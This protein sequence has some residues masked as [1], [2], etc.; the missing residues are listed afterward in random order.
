MTKNRRPRY[1]DA[2]SS[3]SYRVVEKWIHPLRDVSKT[4]GLEDQEMVTVH[5]MRRNLRF[6]GIALVAFAALTTQSQAAMLDLTS[7]GS[8]GD[9]NGATFLTEDI[10]PTGSGNIMSFVRLK[11]TKEGGTAI[12][13]GYNTDGRPTYYQENSSPT[14][15]HSLLLTDVPLVDMDDTLFYEFGLD[16]NQDGSNPLLSLDAVQIYLYTVGDYKGD[17]S[18]LGSP[19]YDLGDNWIALNYDL[20]AGSGQGDM[21]A[22]IPKSLFDLH[23]GDGN[24]VY[25]FS[26]FGNQGGDYANNDGYEEW[27]VRENVTPPPPPPVPAPAAVVLGMLGMSVAGWRLRRF[28]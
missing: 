13:S 2:G 22:Y 6:V 28:A 8:S 1:F 26:M 20:G 12:E 14:F 19:L 3:Q 25:L 21:Y 9:I 27:F 10:A 5:T 17:V 11:E 18:G 4:K 16:I 15:T 7:A 23:A 24:Y